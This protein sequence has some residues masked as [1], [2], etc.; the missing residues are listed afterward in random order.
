M[1][2]GKE[3]G[4]EGGNTTKSRHPFLKNNELPQA[5]FDSNPQCSVI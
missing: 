5:G 4:R 2:G 1:D 3:G